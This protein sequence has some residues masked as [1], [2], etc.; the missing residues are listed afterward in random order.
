[1]IC[2]IHSTQS[3]W[4]SSVSQKEFQGR[5]LYLLH[6]LLGHQHP[7]WHWEIAKYLGISMKLGIL[8]QHTPACVCQ[9]VLSHPC[10]CGPPGPACIQHALTP[11]SGQQATVTGTS[12]PR[13]NKTRPGLSHPSVVRREEAPLKPN[14]QPGA[15]SSHL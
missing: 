11:A 6:L 2:Y 15:S 5:N 4:L 3:S 9:G 14:M 10:L 1:M 7:E 12:T 13:E 8:E